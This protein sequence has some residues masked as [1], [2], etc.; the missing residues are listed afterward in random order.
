MFKK[1]LKHPSFYFNLIKINKKLCYE[2]LIFI[3]IN[4]LESN[5]IV[6]FKKNDIVDYNKIHTLLQIKKLYLSL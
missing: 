4:I 5:S 3:Y 1:Y 6:F 2:L